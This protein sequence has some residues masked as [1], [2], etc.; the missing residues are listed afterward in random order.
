MKIRSGFVSNSSSSS[1]IINYPEK[2]L[3]LSEVE[4]YFGGYNPGVDPYIR[5]IVNYTL[6]KHQFTDSG[7]ELE[8]ASLWHCT[9]PE[10]KE[11]ED[12]WE[13]PYYRRSS[14]SQRCPKHLEYPES[15]ECENCKYYKKSTELENLE[16]CKENCWGDDLKEWYEQVA[17]HLGRI[18]NLSIDD[19]DYDNSDN[20]GLSYEDRYTVNDAAGNLF[21]DHSNIFEEGK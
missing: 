11:E 10:E 6:W 8:Q 3:R 4:D 17:K 18:R 9:L 5:D 21:R 7:K 13:S 14:F 2:P 1:F 19:N 16:S 12:R 15:Y 20:L